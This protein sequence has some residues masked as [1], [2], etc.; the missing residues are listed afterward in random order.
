MDTRSY[1]ISKFQKEPNDKGKIHT[2]CPFHDD[3]HASFSIDVDR[4]LFICGSRKCGVRGGFT[5]FYKMMEG[6]ATWREV[7]QR[8]HSPSIAA[9]LGAVL[10]PKAKVD[11]ESV[12]NDFPFPPFTTTFKTSDIP[13]LRDRGITDEVCEMFGVVYGRDGEFDKVEIKNTLVV[14]IFD[15]DSSYHTF[16]VRRMYDSALRWHTPSGSPIKNL[17]YGG[18]LINNESHLLWIVEGVSDCWNMWQN[19][20]RAVGLFSKEASATQYN[21]IDLLCKTF[22]L[23]PIALLDGDAPDANKK[24]FKELQAYGL[25][26]EAVYLEPDEDPGSLSRLRMM[27]VCGFEKEHKYEQLDEGFGQS[28]DE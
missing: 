18:W 8:L 3:K 24:L 27:S 13:Y 6:L 15:L 17:L 1:I 14:P 19:G 16:Q 10:N 22:E 12:V 2:R 26:P 21:K 5:L 20:L 9:D 11:K 25:K 4:G 7:Y 28:Q 23:T